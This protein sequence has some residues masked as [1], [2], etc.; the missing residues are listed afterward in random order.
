MKKNI[1]I[2]I[3]CYNVKGKILSVINSRYLSEIDK[4]VIVD[5]KCPQKTGLFVKQKLGNKKKIKVIF[6]K[7]NL[8]VGGAT[9]TG[10]KFALKKNFYMIVKIDGDGQH[11]L[12]VIKKFRNQL[13]NDKS[14]FCKG[15][16]NL[17]YSQ[18]KKTK[19]PLIR[20]IGAKCLTILTR[21]NSGHWKLQD[22]CH[23]LIGFNYKILN[24]INLNKIK[25][26]Y[27]FE[28][29]II[30][31]VVKFKGRIKQFKNEVFYNNESSKLN[32][33]MSIIPFLYYHFI[34]F[35]KKF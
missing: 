17:T 29:D 11:N 3:P 14:D 32:P 19:M 9:I 2:V 7:K 6:H 15:F 8:G 10:L 35:L 24:K 31:Q 34:Y 16:R 4:I 25:K 20:L 33:L 13:I 21:L 26:N 18:L 23:G 27:F 22:P 1:C 12:S 5:D 30:M 28:Q